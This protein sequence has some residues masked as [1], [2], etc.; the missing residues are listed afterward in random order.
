MTTVGDVKVRR[1]GG[2]YQPVHEEKGKKNSRGGGTKFLLEKKKKLLMITA[3][4]FMNG[5]SKLRKK[6]GNLQLDSQSTSY[7]RKEEV[8]CDPLL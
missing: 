2:E 1:G 7:G 4:S 6:K 5:K 3:R 8:N